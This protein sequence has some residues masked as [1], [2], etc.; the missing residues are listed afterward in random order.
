MIPLCP[1]PLVDV[2]GRGLVVNHFADLLDYAIRDGF[3]L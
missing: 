2:D 1:P 3:L